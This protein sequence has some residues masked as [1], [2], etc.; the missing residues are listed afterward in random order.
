[1]TARSDHAAEAR[2]LL[3][4]EDHSPL[5]FDTADAQ[6][7]LNVLAA[8]A[9]ATLA[10]VEQKRIANLIALAGLE[11]NGPMRSLAAEP[12]SDYGVRPVEAVRE[13]LGLA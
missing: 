1:M 3:F 5:G 7:T 13:A 11:M 9:H 2:E 4:G 10:L 12:Y 8:Q 6:H